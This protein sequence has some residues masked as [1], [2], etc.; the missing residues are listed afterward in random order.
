MLFSKI[1]QHIDE[2]NHDIRAYVN[3]RLEYFELV[4]LKEVSDTTADIIRAFLLTVIFT[5]AM[6]FIS[7]AVAF[8]LGAALD[9]YS[10]G[11]FLVG[12]FYLLL[13][14]VVLLFGKRFF[15]TLV[16]KTL[17]KKAAKYSKQSSTHTSSKE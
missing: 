14:V 2:L 3:T 15:Q 6:A 4:I 11:F 1:T 10:L 16:V 13:F 7:V 9:N 17:S 12:G 5:I 8:L